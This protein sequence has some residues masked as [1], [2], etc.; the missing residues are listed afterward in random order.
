ME[1]RIREIVREKIFISL[2]EELPY[3]IL[4]DIENLT[5]ENGMLKALV[6]LYVTKDSQ[7]NILIGKQ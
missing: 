3:D 7:K 5:E 1:S 4:V 6:M 2:G